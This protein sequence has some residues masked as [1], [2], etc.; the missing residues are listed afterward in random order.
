MVS[1]SFISAR[2]C[3]DAQDAFIGY[4]HDIWV[5]PFG[6][7]DWTECDEMDS[8]IGRTVPLDHAF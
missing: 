4:D 2:F 6:E 7:C 5:H 3:R 8:V 1:D